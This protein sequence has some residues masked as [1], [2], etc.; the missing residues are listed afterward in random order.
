M[1]RYR[2]R[3]RRRRERASSAT[4]RR[5]S[6][7]P[8][9]RGRLA[10]LPRPERLQTDGCLAGCIAAPL[11]MQSALPNCLTAGRTPLGTTMRAALADDVQRLGPAGPAGSSS[12]GKQGV[13]WRGGAA[14]PSGVGVAGRGGAASA[15]D[16]VSGPALLL[17]CC[18]CSLYCC[19]FSSWNIICA[20]GL[21][22]H[23]TMGWRPPSPPSR[24]LTSISW[25]VATAAIAGHGQ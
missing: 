11:R 10:C 15:R 16:A 18:C 17:R 6:P 2:R 9:R 1:C 4:A 8:R 23:C 25:G 21:R 19:L 3:R 20:T 13:A 5:R 24:Y 22:L 7:S 12:L 14:R